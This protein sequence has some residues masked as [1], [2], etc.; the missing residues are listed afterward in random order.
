MTR[1]NNLCKT[2]LH[3]TVEGGCTQHQQRN[4][5]IAGLCLAHLCQ[6]IWMSPKSIPDPSLGCAWNTECKVTRHQ[7]VLW[8]KK[9]LTKND[10][11]PVHITSNKEVLWMH[12]DP[13]LIANRVTETKQHAISCKEAAQRL[14]E[15]H[16]ISVQL[17]CSLRKE[18]VWSLCGFCAEAAWRMVQWPCSR[19]TIFERAASARCPCRDYAMPLTTGLPATNLWFFQICLTS[20]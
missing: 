16:A 17:L 13:C 12:N 11:Q 9:H 19:R 14:Y 15:N 7:R 6:I 10:L 8:V 1:H 4:K 18:I 20:R 3:G 5:A 2:I